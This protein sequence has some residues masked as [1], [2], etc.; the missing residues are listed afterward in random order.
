MVLENEEKLGT[1]T[2]Y[3]T[4]VVLRKEEEKMQ[5]KREIEEVLIHETTTLSPSENSER[6]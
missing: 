3:L 5:R 4:Y 1:T 2:N 6:W